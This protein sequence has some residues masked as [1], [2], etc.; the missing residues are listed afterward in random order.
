MTQLGK[1]DYLR[2][3][4]SVSEDWRLYL[5]KKETQRNK[6]YLMT[7]SSV[8]FEIFFTQMIRFYDNN[9]HDFFDFWNQTIARI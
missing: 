5:K 7:V 4:L 8:R 6:I 9:S 2:I 3:K 1:S